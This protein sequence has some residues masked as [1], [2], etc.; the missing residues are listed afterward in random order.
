[1]KGYYK[2][3]EATAEVLKDGWLH[4]GD[5]GKMDEDGYLFITDRL[6][7][8]II[9]KGYNVYPRELEEL[10]FQHSAVEQCA[11]VGKPDPDVGEAPVAF[12]KLARG[13]ES[14]REELMQYLN[15]QVAA[16]KKIR[17]LVF[18]DEIPVSGAG[19]VLK[20]EL[21]DRLK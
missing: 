11:V 7:D 15:T 3:P 4:T 6:K 2:Q 9:Y 21:R 5:I 13:Q 1:M 20:R 12:I 17:D 19:K 16:Y 14:T 10:L 18:V 8:M